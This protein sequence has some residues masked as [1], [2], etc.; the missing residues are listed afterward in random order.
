MKSL[1]RIRKRQGRCYEL[2]A[3]VM[4]DEVGADQFTLVHGY[5]HTRFF[6]HAWIELGDGRVFDPVLDVTWSADEYAKRLGAEAEHRYSQMEFAKLMSATRVYGPWTD[7][8][9][10]LTNTE[11]AAA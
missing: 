7:D 9:R 11:E 4:M 5:C 2:A 8:E 3:R 6:G 1:A 10:L